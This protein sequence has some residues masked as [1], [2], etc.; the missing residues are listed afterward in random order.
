MHLEVDGLSVA[1][2]EITVLKNLCLEVSD[3]QIVALLGANGAGKTTAIR[4]LSGLLPWVGG[5]IT[6]GTI[7]LSGAD[8]TRKSAS[9]IVKQ[10]IAHVPEGRRVF[11]SLTVEENLLCGAATKPRKEVRVALAKTYET[12]PRLA[13]L[14]QNRGG[15]LSGGEQQMVAIGRALM[16]SPQLLICDELSLGLAPVF[17]DSLF[18]SLQRLSREEG[19]SILLVEQN[20]RKALTISDHAYV[21]EVGQVALAGPAEQVAADPTI[22]DLYLGAGITRKPVVAP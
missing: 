6:S 12:F 11:A 5:R 14:R 21:L 13:E 3:G 17:I 22:V 1:Y 7:N 4:A 9:A 2:R 20:A 18:D 19:V 10:G 15:F 8:I 16:S